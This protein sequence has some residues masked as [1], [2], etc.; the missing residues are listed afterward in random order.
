[1]IFHVKS[2]R[3]VRGVEMELPVDVGVIYEGERISRD[4]G[5]E[6][7]GDA[8]GVELLRVVPPGEVEDGRVEVLGRDLREMKVGRSYPFALHVKIAGLLAR[9]WR[10]M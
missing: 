1:M 3:E 5:V 2:R 7:G 6:L 10:R 8:T 4:Q 9:G